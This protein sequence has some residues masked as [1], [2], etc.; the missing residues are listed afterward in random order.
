M[1]KGDLKREALIEALANHLLQHGLREVS[2]RPLAAAVG[3]SDRMLLHYFENKNELLTATLVRVSDRLQSMLDAARPEPMPFAE[4]L[5]LLVAMLKDEQVRPYMRLWLELAARAAGG[6][7]LYQTVA[8]RIFDDFYAWIEA[9]IRVEREADRA[10]TASLALA[11]LEGLVLL[12]A[13]GLDARIKSA[14]EGLRQ[15]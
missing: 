14:M 11:T 9:S 2:L 3:T 10:P 5:K 6:D 15:L 7:A 8:S 1:N 4:L 12:D 13:L